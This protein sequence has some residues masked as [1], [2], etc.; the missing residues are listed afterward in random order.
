ME[1]S[2]PMLPRKAT[3][4]L[5]RSIRKGLKDGF[6]HRLLRRHPIYLFTPE[7]DGGSRF[8]SLFRETWNRMPRS[9]Q[10]RILKHWRTAPFE[11][12][13]IDPS[14]RSPEILARTPWQ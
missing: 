4:A 1:T 10:R 8:A 14:V 7:V 11:K 6:F 9:A 12:H 5:R 3:E 13:L 2:N